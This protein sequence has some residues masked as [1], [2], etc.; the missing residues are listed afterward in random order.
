MHLVQEFSST[1]ELSI[2]GYWSLAGLVRSSHVLLC[3]GV[4]LYIGIHYKKAEGKPE[5]R[6]RIGIFMA[7]LF[8]I[9]LLD[10]VSLL[11][12]DDYYHTLTRYNTA[13][14]FALICWP[15]AAL[16]MGIALI[17]GKLKAIRTA[18]VILL[19]GAATQFIFY[20]FFYSEFLSSQFSLN[21][22]SLLDIMNV[23]LILIIALVSLAFP[24]AVFVW[25]LALYKHSKVEVEHSDE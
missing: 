16:V 15:L 2:A 8:G 14:I 3:V 22:N 13:K 25:A 23:L 12:T 17:N 1:V 24:V 9:S 6:K 18:S 5:N 19:F 7:V 10:H 20:L 11:L 21:F 4:F